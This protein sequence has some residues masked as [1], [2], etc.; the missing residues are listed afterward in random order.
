M[1]RVLLGLLLVAGVHNV[2]ALEKQQ[3]PAII[4]A[5][6]ENQLKVVMELLNKEQRNA[7]VVYFQQTPLDCGY[8]NLHR[9]Q[10][11]VETTQT[12]LATL[13]RAYRLSPPLE[14]NQDINELDRI[15]KARHDYTVARQLLADCEEICKI[16]AEHGGKIRNDLVEDAAAQDQRSENL[17]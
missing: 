10:N 3:Q 13:E 15:E 5:V 14:R 1:K 2:Q 11:K 6:S 8:Y 17:R 4:T 12:L 16:I 7:N 9:F